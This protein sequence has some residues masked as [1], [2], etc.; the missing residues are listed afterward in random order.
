MSSLKDPSEETMPFE[1][2]KEHLDLLIHVTLPAES[3]PWKHIHDWNIG[4]G[5]S[6]L[7]L[8]RKTGASILSTSNTYIVIS[9]CVCDMSFF[10]IELDCTCIIRD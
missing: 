10:L 7:P 1:S 8:G 5:G 4:E 3:Y 9:G 2:S 6:S